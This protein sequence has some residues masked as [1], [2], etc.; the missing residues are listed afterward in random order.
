MKRKIITIDEEKCNGCG[1]C[2]GGCPEGAI[3]IIDGKA[4]LINDL[5]CDGLGAC[6]GT[7]PQGAI[8][9]EEREARPYSEKETMGNIVKHGSQTIQA[10]LKHLA[11]HGQQ[12]Y[13]RE[14]LEYLREKN[15]KVDLPDLRPHTK[16]DTSPHQPSA[17]YGESQLQNWPVQLQLL[18]PA[19]PYFQNAELVIAADCSSFAYADFHQRFLQGKILIIL[20]PKLDRVLEEYIEKLSELF[21]LN[22]IKSL[23]LVHM[24]VPCCFGLVKIVEE[25]IARSGKQITVKEYTISINGEVV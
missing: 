7:C 13:L 23:S 14:A 20:C 16:K 24:E 6:I 5:F 9:I 19:A 4:R 3:Q 17:S 10:H 15:I 21:K 11:G 1:N 2:A 8:T 22:T 12:Q 18:N 25:A